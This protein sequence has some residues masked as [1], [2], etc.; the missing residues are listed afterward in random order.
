MGRRDCWAREPSMVAILRPIHRTPASNKLEGRR[1]SRP[2]S[3]WLLLGWMLAS[4]SGWLAGWL[5]GGSSRLAGTEG[6]GKYILEPPPYSHLHHHHH[7]HLYHQTTPK[8][9]ETTEMDEQKKHA[10][11]DE[12]RS[13]PMPRPLAPFLAS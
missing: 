2:L 6:Q 5:L 3:G 1:E 4:L 7:C 9:P 10:A 8:L 11:C 13:L 12:C